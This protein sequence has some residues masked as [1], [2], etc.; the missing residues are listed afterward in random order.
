MELREDAMVT[1]MT[2][3]MEGKKSMMTRRQVSSASTS[4]NPTQAPSHDDAC[5]TFL[6]VVDKS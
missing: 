1:Q 4:H 3:A 6:Q 5:L 2:V